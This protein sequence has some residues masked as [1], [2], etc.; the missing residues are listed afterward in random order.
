[1]SLLLQQGRWVRALVRSPEAAAKALSDLPRGPG[2]RL[3]LV[4][5]DL[6]VPGGLPEGMG[7]GV[8]AVIHA[9][10]ARVQPKE[11]DTA[12]RAKYKQGIVFYE[13]EVVSSPEAIEYKGMEVSWR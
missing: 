12:D 10:S 1:M 11:G 4:Q 3:E 6:G 5:G 8:R 7:K 9:A 13:P 2:A